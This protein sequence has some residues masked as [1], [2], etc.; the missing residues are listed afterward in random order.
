MILDSSALVAVLAGEP[1][2]AQFIEAISRAP[3]C[4]ISAA[5][6]VEI[7]IVLEAQHG[8]EV[9]RQFDALMHR[10]HV[11]IEPVTEEQARLARQAYIDYG[12]GRH[13]AGLNYGDCFSYAL[14]KSINEPL[15][16]KG[17]DFAKTDMKSAL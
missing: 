10:A 2:R 16:F 9:L 15:L 14:A 4:R 6:Y 7:S 12:K 3:V 13:P 1:D 5:T 11:A 8:P 17:Q